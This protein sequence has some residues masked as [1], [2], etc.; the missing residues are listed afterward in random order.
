M[1]FIN[2]PLRCFNGSLKLVGYYNILY[3]LFSDVLSA[4]SLI[5]LCGDVTYTATRIMKEQPGEPVTLP[6][7]SVMCQAASQVV[8]YALGAIWYLATSLLL[9]L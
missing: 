7:T 3:N 6:G 2:G 4:R 1:T 5:L 8:Y 9:W